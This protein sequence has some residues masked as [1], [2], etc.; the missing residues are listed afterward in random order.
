MTAA[1]T[2]PRCPSCGQAMHEYAVVY[3]LCTCSTVLYRFSELT[4]SGLIAAANAMHPYGYVPPR[5]P[6]PACGATNPLDPEAPGQF[7]AA[8]A[9]IGLPSLTLAHVTGAGDLSKPFGSVF[10][11]N[12]ARVTWS[13]SRVSAE[14]HQVLLH[15]ARTTTTSGSARCS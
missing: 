11:H 2:A 5:V 4:D 7:F 1:D 3:W 6:C 8:I 14:G 9:R 10:W 12:L 15:P 13:A